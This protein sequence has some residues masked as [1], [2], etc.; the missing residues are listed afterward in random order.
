MSVAMSKTRVD[1]PFFVQP[2]VRVDRQYY[3]D[4]LL[5]QNMLSAMKKVVDNSNSVRNMPIYIFMQCTNSV[6]MA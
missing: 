3:H 4:E 6:M 2:R 1:G 5:S